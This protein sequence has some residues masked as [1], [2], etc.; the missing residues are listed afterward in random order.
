M[1][2]RQ[3]QM[4]AALRSFEER[5]ETVL[6]AELMPLAGPDADFAEDE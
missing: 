1:A 4:R 5:L 6:G 3:D 2:F